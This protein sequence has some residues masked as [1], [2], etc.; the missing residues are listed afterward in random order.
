MR[1]P[2]RHCRRSSA[3]A[4]RSGYRTSIAVAHRL[5]TAARAEVVLVMDRGRLV[6]VGSHDDLVS[7]GGSYAELFE[8]WLSMT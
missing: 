6:E 7:R 3:C 2:N 5:S 4:V 1:E 8:R